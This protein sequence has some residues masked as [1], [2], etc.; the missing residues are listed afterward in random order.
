M[1]ISSLGLGSGVLTQDVLDKLRKGDEAQRITPIDF[2]LALAKD[3]KAAFST[4]D[5]NMTNLIDSIN[6][7]KSQNLYDQRTADIT[8][9]SVEVTADANADVQDFTLDVTQL[10]TKEIDESDAFGAESDKIATDSGS[11]T[12]D[13]NDADGNTTKSFD[14]DY[15]ADMTLKDLKNAINK[16]AGSD[17]KAS[18]VKV[19]DGDVRLFL[20][21]VHEGVDQ[22]FSITDNDGNLSDDGG[23]TN[24]GTNLTDNLSTVQDGVDAEFTFNG[25]D[26]RR[27]SNQVDDLVTGYHIKLLELGSSDVSVKQN[28]DEIM[29]R[30]DSF[31]KKYNSA[32]NEITS[33]TKNSTNKDER[34]IFA[35]E[36]TIK[37]MQSTIRNA[38]DTIG[39]GVG[40]IYDYGFDV[41]KNG[42]LS[43]NKDTLNEKLDKNAK[44]VE[45]FFSGGDFDNGDGTTTT[46]DGAFTELSKT[47]ESYTAY[48]QTL[49]QF[50]NDLND[51]TSN[52]EDKRTTTMERLNSKYETLQKQWASYDSLI[53]RLNSSANAF[54]QMINSQNASKNN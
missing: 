20:N 25:Q 48:N 3:K 1:A 38:L 51:Y 13:I 53:S 32:M 45:V 4:L 21:A 54:I 47:V 37:S 31:V 43:V 23:N 42:K 49:D 5:A 8:G 36:S 15:D 19:G 9:S 27:S 2:E 52:L 10:A 46:I 11:M 33:L 50:K 22:K 17:V 44:N 16:V 6:E 28:R 14:I 34:G 41:D 26:I 29:K 7:L 35:S 18:I 39:D 40:T 30:I 12:I 24:G